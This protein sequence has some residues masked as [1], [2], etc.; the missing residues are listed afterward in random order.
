VVLPHTRAQAFAISDFPDRFAEDPS[1]RAPAPGP[2][3][4]AEIETTTSGL[5]A[6]KRRAGRRFEGNEPPKP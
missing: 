4:D 2:R 6:A 1:L 3:K 5:L